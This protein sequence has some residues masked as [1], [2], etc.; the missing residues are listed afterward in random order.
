MNGEIDDN[1]VDKVDF[2]PIMTDALTRR[3]INKIKKIYEKFPEMSIH[4]SEWTQKLFEEFYNEPGSPKSEL[5]ELY[6]DRIAELKAPVDHE[7]F[8]SI[9]SFL[10]Y[11]Y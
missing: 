7:T 9:Q 11:F 1:N 5:L 2:L 8:G 10:R 3:D 6:F 4:L